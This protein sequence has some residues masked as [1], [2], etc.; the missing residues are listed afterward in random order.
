MLVATAP[1]KSMFFSLR[2]VASRASRIAAPAPWASPR[3]AQRDE[4]ESSTTT[5][6]STASNMLPAV[7]PWS[8]YCGPVGTPMAP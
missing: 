5:P 7:V 4:S 2:R 3:I 6:A 8:M 1:R